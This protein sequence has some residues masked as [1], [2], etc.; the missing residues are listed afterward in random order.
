MYI[1]KMEQ[2]LKKRFCFLDN[3]ILI[4]YSKLL[5]LQRKYLWSEVDTW[6]KSPKISLI[7][8]RDIF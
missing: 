6:T 3:C 8:N 1:L 4:C 2:K 7:T 5:L